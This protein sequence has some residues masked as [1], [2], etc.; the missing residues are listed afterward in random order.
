MLVMSESAISGPV[1]AVPVV[2]AR[3]RL[4]PALTGYALLLP[5]ALFL[6]AF[7]YWPVLQV[8]L[9]SLTV[10]SFGGAATR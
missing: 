2:Y 5:S 10:R 4:R 3:R 1:A 6:I 7:T 9:S 8:L